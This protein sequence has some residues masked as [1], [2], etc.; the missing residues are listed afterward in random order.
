[1]QHMS[2]P[3][4]GEIRMVGFNF[5]PVG[6]LACQGQ[7]LPISEYDVLFNLIGTTYGG[8]GQNTFALPNLQSRVPIHAGQGGGLSPRVIGQTGGAEQVTLTTQ[9]I[10]S[11]SHVPQA[12]TQ[13]SSSSP[14]NNFWGGWTGLEYS[15]SAPNAQTAADVNPS[16]G[17]QPHDNMVPFLVINFVIATEGIYPTPN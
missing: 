16:G 9:L 3:Y 7:L 2:T 10:P 11:H 5:A 17:S 8:D 14:T 12:N 15:S 13:A 4:I 6:W 1:M